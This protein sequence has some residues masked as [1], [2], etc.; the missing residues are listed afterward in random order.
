MAPAKYRGGLVAMQ[1][2]MIVT[3]VASAFWL[4]YLCLVRFPTSSLA[5]RIPLSVQCMAGMVLVVGMFWMPESIRYLIQKDQVALA[6]K[7]LAFVRRLPEDNPYVQYEFEEIHT[8]VTKEMEIGVGRW[9]DLWGK[10]VRRQLLIGS[11]LQCF[12]QL[13]GTNATTYYAISF[14]KHQLLI[15]RLPLYFF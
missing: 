10:D 14:C 5:F 13:S 7:N 11:F 9:R 6:R 12:Q 1:Q 4:D 15:F 2:L 8:V 3:G